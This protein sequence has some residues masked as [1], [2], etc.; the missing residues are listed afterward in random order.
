MI[1]HSKKKNVSHTL[2]GREI[3]RG[4]TALRRTR[5]YLALLKVLVSSLI[6]KFVV[7][8]KQVR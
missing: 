1:I 5:I 3:V 6:S 4:G 2:A 7:N 8:I